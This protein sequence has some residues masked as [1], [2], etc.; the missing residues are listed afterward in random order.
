MSI[1]FSKGIGYWKDLIDQL[2]SMLNDFW[3]YITGSPLFSNTTDP[4]NGVDHTEFV[5]PTLDD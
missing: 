2:L 3:T 5:P 1:D 4:E